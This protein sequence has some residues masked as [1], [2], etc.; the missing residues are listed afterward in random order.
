MLRANPS[1][2][3]AVANSTFGAAW[4]TIRKQCTRQV[5]SD[6][7]AMICGLLAIS[8]AF[9]NPFSISLT[10][11]LLGVMAVWWLLV[12]RFREQA[13]TLSRN[14]VALATLAIVVLMSL[15]VFYGAA[16]LTESVPILRKYR[17]LAYLVLFT[18][19]FR[20]SRTRAMAVLAF[21]AAMVITLV[22]SILTAIG[23][24]PI[25]NRH[26]L[27][28]ANATVFNNHIVH[29]ICMS[30]FAYLIAHRFVDQPRWRWLTGPLALL[31]M[32]NTFF[33][34]GGRTGYLTLAALIP[35]FCVQR[36]RMRQV[37]YLAVAVGGI[38]LVGCHFSSVFN[39]RIRVAAREVSGYVDHH[40]RGGPLVPEGW[41]MPVTSTS[42]GL[43][44]EWYRAGLQLLA[45]NPLLGVGVGNVKHHLEQDGGF[46]ATYNL[47]SEYAMVAA[48]TGLL[49]TALFAIFFVAHWRTSRLLSPPMRHV[50]DGVLVLM[51][52]AGSVN[53]LLTERTEGVL[54]ALF[55]GLAFAEI[56]ER[57]VRKRQD[58]ASGTDTTAD[59]AGGPP[60]ARAA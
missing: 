1:T 37:V 36:L 15:S 24:P 38:A 8:I 6:R 55:S 11:I 58:T 44:L 34:V 59:A 27:N 33:M 51:L 60:L 12:G 52:V 42:C 19:V 53:S 32:W 54:F 2:P 3:A 21:E 40:F 18:L 50:A 43:R 31:A 5:V 22:G 14:P 20:T 4:S 41:N 25:E 26:T 45:K 10:E 9:T 39:E 35:L 16:P 48:Q 28:P 47:H 23:V 29:G 49:G 7:A 56:S 57:A 46:L 30:F 17:T 13:Y